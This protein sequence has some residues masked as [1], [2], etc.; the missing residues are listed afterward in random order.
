MTTPA[1]IST[2]ADLALEPPLLN[3]QPLP[4][5]DAARLDYGMTIGIERTPGGRLWAC[6]V[7]GGDNDKAFFILATSDDGGD[8]WSKPRLVIDPH[9]A[10]LPYPRRSLVGNLWTD[11]RGRLWLFFDQAM[12][13]F[14]GRGGLWA[15][16][17]ENPD[18]DTPEWSSPRRIWHG[19]ALNKPVILSNGEWLL[20]ASL[21]DRGRNKAPFEDAFP[22][23]DPFRGANVLVSAD[24]G[25]TWSRR[26][27]VQFPKPSFDEHHFI[28][29]RDGSLWMTARTRTGMWE[30]HSKDNGRTWTDPQPAAIAQPAA[31]HHLQR[32][33]SGRLLLIK[34]G[35]RIDELPEDDGGP[36]LRSFLT[37]FLSDDEGASWYGG[38]VLDERK[39]ISYPDGFEAPDGTIHISYDW[40]RDREGEVLLAQFREADV[41]A[42]CLVTSGSRLKQRISKPLGI[43]ADGR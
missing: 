20:P 19:C 11:P 27:T 13:Y 43:R 3:T 24:E 12:T 7:G 42:G 23:L 15:T 36:G 37:A 21:W 29:R 8:T 39:A 32:L 10:S 6:W 28:E 41:V 1:T 16:L 18:A 25:A 31:R 17:C 5:Y 35:R 33:S 2:L 4:D 9:S 40:E 34:H 38:L 22:E 30:C 26:A 14:D